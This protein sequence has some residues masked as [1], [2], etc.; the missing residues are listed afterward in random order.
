MGD[1][2]LLQMEDFRTE[3]LCFDTPKEGEGGA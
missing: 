2:F 3:G 1:L